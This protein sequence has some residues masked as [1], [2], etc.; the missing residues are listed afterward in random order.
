[1]AP[2]SPPEGT[3]L[4][5][6]ADPLWLPVRVQTEGRAEKSRI[7]SGLQME[8]G[9]CNSCKVAERKVSS[10]A[11]SADSLPSL[12]HQKWRWTRAWLHRGQLVS[13]QL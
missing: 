11:D 6:G 10:L 1:M 7:Q 3:G 12:S 9:S 13:G 2:V 8:F 4:A 5:R